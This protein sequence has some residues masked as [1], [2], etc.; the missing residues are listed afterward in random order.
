MQNVLT[1]TIP[2]ELYQ[3]LEQA[4]LLPNE[5]KG[6][7]KQRKGNKDQLIKDKMVIKN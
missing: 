1:G 5:Q 4:E 6:C 3:H 2:E 7:T